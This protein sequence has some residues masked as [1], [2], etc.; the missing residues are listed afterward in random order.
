MADVNP[1]QDLR[2]KEI[3]KRV[4]PGASFF[5]Y[6]FIV[7][8]LV[9]TEPIYFQQQLS[10]VTNNVNDGVE[11]ALW[12]L[13]TYIGGFV[14]NS[15]ASFWERNLCYRLFN[16]P[17]KKVLTFGGKDEIEGADNIIKDSK[18]RLSFRSITNDESRCVLRFVK[19]HIVRKDNLVKLLKK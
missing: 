14:I 4:I 18:V 6:I 10:N 19:N 2:F 3:M 16:R 5:S 17:S 1:N 12:L 8:K 11:V 15:M 7:W 9:T 13:V